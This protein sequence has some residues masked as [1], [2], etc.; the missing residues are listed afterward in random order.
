MLNATKELITLNRPIDNYCYRNY[1]IDLINQYGGIDDAKTLFIK[2]RETREPELLDPIAFHGD[3]ELSENLFKL[4]IKNNRLIKGFPEE[5]FNTISYL[6]NPNLES[7]LIY[8]LKKSFEDKKLPEETS[9]RF[10]ISVCESLLNYS[11]DGY[12]DIISDQIEKCL[13]KYLF[14]EY[15]PCLAIKTKNNKFFRKLHKKVLNVDSDCNNGLILG[16]ALFGKSKKQIFKSIIW[17]SYLEIGFGY[18]AWGAYLG[19]N[20]LGITINELFEEIFNDY[21]KNKDKD[22]ICSKIY[23]LC[24]ILECKIYEPYKFK[25]KMINKINES[26]ISIY[27]SLFKYKNPN[28]DKTIIGIYRDYVKEDILY[29]KLIKL[30]SIIELRMEKEIRENN[31]FIEKI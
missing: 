17:N 26:Y 3:S 9:Y 29:Q 30:E 28:K 20:Y 4:C 1:L 23:I 24:E 14:P 8:Y 16:L 6:E 10:H 13:S 12:E 25:I 2:F 18:G 21:I 5:V 15:I 27:N 11:C 19:M 7:V 22:S 31:Y